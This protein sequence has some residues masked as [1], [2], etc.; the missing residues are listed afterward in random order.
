ML[1]LCLIGGLVMND[2]TLHNFSVCERVDI[3]ALDCGH[4]FAVQLWLRGE[5]AFACSG[6]DVLVYSSPVEAAEA[7]RHCLRPGVVIGF[8][9]EH[10]F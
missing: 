9:V 10:F 6:N 8:P 4:G 5:S 7:I 3:I 1:R 2:D